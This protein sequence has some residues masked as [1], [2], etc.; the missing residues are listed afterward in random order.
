[1]YTF[2]LTQTLGCT[3]EEAAELEFEPIILFNKLNMAIGSFYNETD[4]PYIIIY[5]SIYTDPDDN[6][7]PTKI[8]RI[9]L[10]RYNIIQKYPTLNKFTQ[11]ELSEII[12][13]IVDNWDFIRELYMYTYINKFGK[14]VYIPK[15]CPYKNDKYVTSIDTDNKLWK[16][17]D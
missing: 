5:N 13:L 10:M 9:S 15:E 14:C 3:A 16:W 11:N 6:N 4:E 1:M 8:A 7:A 17:G 2:Y 12:K